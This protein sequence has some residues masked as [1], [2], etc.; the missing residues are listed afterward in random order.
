MKPLHIIAIALFY[1]FSYTVYAQDVKDIHLVDP[2]PELSLENAFSSGDTLDLTVLLNYADSL[3]ATEKYADCLELCDR[4]KERCPDINFDI[5]YLSKT[6]ECHY[7]LKNY[8]KA[9]ENILEYRNKLGEDNDLSLYY[10][11]I[12]ANSLYNTY[13]YKEAEIE[14]E[15]YF[16]IILDLEGL[17]MSEIY[18]SKNKRNLGKYLYDYAYNSFFMG[19]E[20]K[21]L[22]LLSLA[23]QCGNRWAID[24]YKHLV[25]CKTMYM[26]LDIPKKLRRQFR[27]DIGR[28]DFKY[29]KPGNSTINISEDFWEKF[30]A[31]NS[32]VQELNRQMGRD[33]KKKVLQKALDELSNNQHKLVSYLDEHCNPFEAGD[34]ELNLVDK[35]S[36]NDYVLR[37]NLKIYPASENNAFATPYGQIYLTSGLVNQYH[38]NEHLLIGICAH[39]MTHYKCSHTLVKLWKQ[40]EKERRTLITACIVA[41]LYAT[42][43]IGTAAVAS[44]DGYDFDSSYFD[45]VTHTTLDLLSIIADSSYYFQFKYSRGQ[46]IESDLMAYKFCEAIGLGGYAYIMALQLL[47]ENDLYINVEKTDDHPN[48]TYR[49]LLLKWLHFTENHPQ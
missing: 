30:L 24:D 17:K 32:S 35:L 45:A 49:I 11:E 4:W 2:I 19:N 29:T 42:A 26:D 28:Y 37:N 38:S 44:Y 15:K 20:S 10:R 36:N 8:S 43:M 3:I 13:R 48:I 7:Y 6:G 33:K 1:S 9:I 14:Y 40:Y 31:Q 39:E 12:Y 25:N 41:G 5:L 46:E 23:S 47:R 21:G 27:N 22:Y 16:N 18:L 34:I